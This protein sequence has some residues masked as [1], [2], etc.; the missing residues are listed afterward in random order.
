M[1]PSMIA[2]LSNWR[3]SFQ[4]RFLNEVI[5][6]LS[7]IAIA[8]A[9]LLSLLLLKVYHF[10]QRFNHIQLSLDQLNQHFRN[11]QLSGKEFLLNEKSN[12]QFHES[13]KS[14]HI[15]QITTSSEAFR[16]SLKTIQ[17]LT[18]SQFTQTTSKLLTAETQVFRTLTVI[19][20]TT[21]SLGYKDWGIEGEWRKNIH[22]LER[23]F[24]D[25]QTK[26]RSEY[27][28][29]YLQLRRDEK[30]FLARHDP[31]YIDSI[32]RGLA[33]LQEKIQKD[34]QFKASETFLLNK[35][36]DLFKQ[37]L[38]Y[39][40]KRHELESGL[41]QAEA[42]TTLALMDYRSELESILEKEKTS[43]VMA[44]SGSVVLMFFMI[45]ILVIRQAKS[46]LK[47]IEKMKDFFVQVGQGD[48]EKNLELNRHD[49]FLVLQTEFNS[50]LSNLRASKAQF[51]MAT[52]GE[53][54]ANIAHD[55]SNPLSVV[56]YYLGKFKTNWEKA[57]FVFNPGEALPVLEKI[58]KSAV[59]MDK[60]ITSVKMLAR[61]A[62]DSDFRIVSLKQVIDE[63]LFFI[64]IK[65][66][67]SGVSLK[68]DLP[69]KDLHVRCNQ[70]LISQVIVNLVSNS[71]DAIEKLDDRWLHI[72]ARELDQDLEICLTDSGPGIPEEL[73]KNLFHVSVTTKETGKG[74]GLGLM[75]VK[76]IVDRHSGTIAVEDFKNTRFV[77]R[78]PKVDSL[79]KP[80]QIAS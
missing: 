34:P 49:E 18:D 51:R 80:D 2:Q 13:G 47:P 28:V 39:H 22:Q 63:S 70:T 38:V 46:L 24:K 42:Q 8:S 60:V 55:L 10:D 33:D 74:T 37:Y 72:T 30:D 15:D 12:P 52:I 21:K 68:V 57:D 5:L 29:S 3:R 41:R 9:V 77:I 64:D 45:L 4:T 61:Q 73:R 36:S 14:V 25:L 54:S 44:L 1:E 16:Q 78:L 6:R 35:Y 31:V 75:M 20:D 40:N 19:I 66:R 69:V 48:L 27:L 7:T 76:Q 62:D 65:L 23:F 17:I 71:I 32:F 11:E 56:L 67:K 59:R 58:K 26:S 79:E 50:M 43:L 53:I